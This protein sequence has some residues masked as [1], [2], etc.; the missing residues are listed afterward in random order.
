[1]INLQFAIGTGPI[2]GTPSASLMH[3]WLP[4]AV[5][6]FMVL[7]A[8][9]HCPAGEPYLSFLRGLQGRGYGEQALS[10]LDSI[11]ANPDLPEEI[12]GA[13]DY[14]RSKCLKIAAGEAYDATQRDS[15]LAEAKR[16]A[17]KFF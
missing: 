11:S 16:L 9:P 2:L 3:R 17:D 4:V 12:K 13:L 8:A 6:L 5:C 14:E 15:R 7:T 10:Y 1:M